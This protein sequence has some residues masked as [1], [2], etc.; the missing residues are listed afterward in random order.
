MDPAGS[1]PNSPSVLAL[2]KWRSIYPVYINSR[3]TTAEGRRIRKDKCVDNPTCQEIKDILDN[4]GLRNMIEPRKMYARDASRDLGYQGRVK[5]ELLTEQQEPVNPKF[6][7]KL[8]VLH[9]LGETIP[10]LK[11]RS[12]G[13]Q[14]SSSAA[15]SSSQ[16]GGT[17]KGKS[18]GKG[19]KRK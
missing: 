10:K 8:A 14:Q 13:N 15:G 2:K 6:P 16:G 11:S 9:Y 12:S 17:S 1:G 19:G 18:K 3:K 4:I 5:V 7:N